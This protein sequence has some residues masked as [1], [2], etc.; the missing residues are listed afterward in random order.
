MSVSLSRYIFLILFLASPL[1][2]TAPAFGQEATDTVT[3]EFEKMW[4]EYDVR[5]NDIK[6]MRVHTA[7]TIHN[8]KD[9]TGYLSV[10]ILGEDDE[11]LKT[12]TSGYKNK[13]GD[14]AIFKKLTPLYPDAYYED[15]AVFVPYREIKLDG[16]T[17]K[18]KIDADLIY[19]NGDFIHHFTLHEFTFTQP[20]QQQASV[21][22][23]TAGLVDFER[24]WVDYDVTQ[25]NELGMRLHVKLT[26]RNLSGVSSQLA[27]AIELENGDK[28]YPVTSAFASTNGQLTVYRDLNVKFANS[29]FSDVQVFMPYGEIKVGSGRHDLRVHV[30]LLY[31]DGGNL[32]VAYHDF[33]FTK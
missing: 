27:Y 2:F 6:G 28:V 8:M 17:H 16:G 19:E 4:V 26:V 18:L 13:A 11:A 31:G 33:N 10:R 1:F 3:A 12:P 30:D 32:H 15:Y 14:L 29:V 24:M 5:E 25:N 21:E 9:V 22:K 20:E 23:T 7:F